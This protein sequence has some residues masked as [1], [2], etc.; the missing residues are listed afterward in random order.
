V[1]VAKAAAA[2]AVDKHLPTGKKYAY[3]GKGKT[4]NVKDVVCY[5]I[6][7]SEFDIIDT[8]KK[9]VIGYRFDDDTL[10]NI[11][12]VATDI[13]WASSTENKFVDLSWDSVPASFKRISA[14]NKMKKHLFEIHGIDDQST[15][16]PP[17][18]RRGTLE[19][20]NR[21]KERKRKHDN[22]DNP[23]GVDL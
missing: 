13:R 22:K 10:A 12:L 1:A 14:F 18:F 15:H 23:S 6:G 20:D 17:L 7:C 19:S 9:C 21:K 11:G 4:G 8:K 16:C 3:G 2:A 5:A